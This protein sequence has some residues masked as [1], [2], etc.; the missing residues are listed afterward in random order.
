MVS[1]SEMEEMLEATIAEVRGFD[2]PV[3]IEFHL[4][5]LQSRTPT[6][7]LTRMTADANKIIAAVKRG[8]KC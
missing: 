4:F 3:K 5:E 2:G 6:V 1:N 8:T 7:R